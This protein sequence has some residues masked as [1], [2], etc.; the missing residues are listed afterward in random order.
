MWHGDDLYFVS[1]RGADQRLNIWKSEG[2][3][4]AITQVTRFTDF[5]VKWPAIGPGDQGQGEIVFQ[6]NSGLFLVDLGSGQARQ[7]KVQI[8]GARASIR[9]NQQLPGDP[10]LFILRSTRP[11][12]LILARR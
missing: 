1:D 12:K 3:S 11:A 5:D 8:P 10:H 7:V 4:G 6:N 2:A 9:R